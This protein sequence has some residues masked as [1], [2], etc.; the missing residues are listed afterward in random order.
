MIPRINPAGRSFKGLAQYLA[1][2]P[3]ANTAERVAWT[4]T[5]NCVHDDVLS[6]VHE[7]YSTAMDAD[8]L[9]QEA[10]IRAGGRSLEKPVRH[11]SLN[12]HPSDE[13]TREHIIEAAQSFLNR[14]GWGEHQA[15]LFAHKDKDHAHV[16][17]ILNAVHPETGLA[18]DDGLERRRASRWALDYEREQGKVWC[19]QRLLD[20]AER[21]ASPTREA[22][23][24]LNDSERQHDQAEARRVFN[25]DY[26]ARDD[27]RRVTE[28]EEWKILKEHQRHEREAF[29][30]DGKRA[31]T[32]LR[33]IVYREVREEFRAEWAAYYAAKRDGQDAAELAELR[34]NILARQRTMLD[35]CRTEACAA[36]RGHRDEQYVE[37]LADQKLL[38]ADLAA[39]QQED[40]SSPQ[41]LCLVGEPLAD[42]AQPDQPRQ[43]GEA[44]TEKSL[45]PPASG[46]DLYDGFQSAADETCVPATE[47]TDSGWEWPQEVPEITWAENPRARDPAN[48][49]ADLGLGV[50][51]ALATIGER[52][53]DGFLGGVGPRPERERAPSRQEGETPR[54]SAATKAAEQLRESVDHE[55]EQVRNR[56]YWDD[57]QRERGRE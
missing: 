52:L 3:K 55:R 29:F 25:S 50:L 36:L 39:R 46:A 40:L 48:A 4:H 21:E 12:W 49:V 20:P 38:R 30:A 9:K 33:K 41:L 42:S 37:L 19:T 1:H 35:G 57:R 2:D 34:A 7:M 16:H 54:V 51:G 5:L 10:G 17:C 23:L 11:F 22:W 45:R 53:F 31:F 27:N 28:K 32:E 8:L 18:L 56:R 26:L 13:P 47:R 15:I 6:A 43:A 14:M 24:A 44:T